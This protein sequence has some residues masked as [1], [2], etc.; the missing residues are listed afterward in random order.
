MNGSCRLKTRRQKV[1]QGLTPKQIGWSG[2]GRRSMR[3][4]LCS[5]DTNAFK[6][7]LQFEI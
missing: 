5:A 1:G 3:V 2:I 4:E 6:S 7:I